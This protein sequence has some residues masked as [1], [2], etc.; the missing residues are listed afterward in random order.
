MATWLINSAAAG[1]TATGAVATT[2][3]LT[4]TAYTLAG[5][6]TASVATTTTL[7][8]TAYTGPQPVIG[9]LVN[10][11]VTAGTTISGIT[12]PWNGT[13]GVYTITG[14][15]VATVASQSMT[16]GSV[17]VIGNTVSGGVTAGTTISGIT[18]SW[19]G[20]TG[21]YTIT[22]NA[23][24][25]VASQAM[26]IGLSGTT[27]NGWVNALQTTGA[28]IT[29]SVAGD[30]FNILSTSYENFSTAQTLT[31]K[32]TAV[33]PNRVFS[34]TNTHAPA[35]GTDLSA[36]ATIT[37][38][39][40]PS[41]LTITG[42]VYIYGVTFNA[43][44]G[45]TSG[46]ITFGNTTASEF[47][48]ENCLIW[49]RAT[50]SATAIAFTSGGFTVPLKVTLIN[51]VMALNGAVG[52]AIQISYCTFLWKNT[53]NAIQGTQ[54]ALTAPFLVRCST[55]IFDGIDF[56]GGTGVAAG[57]S[58]V[59]NAGAAGYTQIANCSLNSGTFPAV[60]PTVIGS[61][62]DL[63]ISDSTGTGYRQERYD[64]QG[65]LTTS[66]SIY[67]TAS[68]GIRSISWAVVSTA[69]AKRQSPFECFEFATWAAS[70]T[71]AASTV[72][73]TSFTAGLTNADVWA[74]VEY[75]GAGSG[76]TPQSFMVSSA[77]ANLLTSGTG[78]AAGT[79][80]VGGQGSNYQ[81]AIP[82]FTTTISGLVRVIVKVAR[83]STTVYVDPN[84]TIA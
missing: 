47:V 11:G 52:S 2:T 84:I 30:D 31:F 70:G 45:G 57:K 69:N 38:T 63:I 25:T 19:N 54:N 23:V 36:G 16:I 76:S 68:D 75:M 27:A 48:L 44:Y 5:T 17:P 56:I 41:A 53:A 8:I 1:G 61:R 22:G 29:A 14:N 12:T 13:T 59:T 28:A 78:L 55:C 32:G 35:Q 26:T 33:S 43:A 77:P 10:G 9:M 51:T 40:A 15:A 20:S 58:L 79:W 82:S 62:V 7:T 65:T 80:A 67:N 60:T 81:I 73:L 83:A 74:E 64:Y 71:Y 4:L 46:N 24:A 42:F 50:T 37:T 39:G 21:V 66:S 3:T 72:Q 6:A 34:T 49:D 18:T